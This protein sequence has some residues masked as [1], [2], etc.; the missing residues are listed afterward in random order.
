MKRLFRRIIINLCR[1]DY[2][3]EKIRKHNLYS[4]YV[5]LF[6]Y[7]T[8]GVDWKFDFSEKFHM[9]IGLHTYIWWSIVFLQNLTT[10]LFFL[11]TKYLK[12]FSKE[13]RNHLLNEKTVTVG[14]KDNILQ[15][16]KV[17]NVIDDGV[18]GMYGRFIQTPSIDF[19]KT[20]NGYYAGNQEI[21]TEQI[22]KF[23]PQENR[24][25]KLQKLS[26]IEKE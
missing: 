15:F 22:F 13:Y 18:S 24:K 9:S 6:L 3:L 2:T 7:I 10:L 8:V 16:G 19:E 23:L 5:F 21:K 12:K 26:K 20:F 1:K 11:Y 14:Y 4:I 25:L 17:Y